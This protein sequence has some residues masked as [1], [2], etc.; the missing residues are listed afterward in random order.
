MGASPERAKLAR[1]YPTGTTDVS[2]LHYEMIQGLVETHDAASRDIGLSRLQQAV[3]RSRKGTSSA[4]REAL[5]MIVRG[6]EAAGQPNSALV[7]L[8][9]VVQLNRDS[10]VRNVLQHHHLHLAKVSRDLDR[11]AQAAIEMQ[12]KELRFQRLS[13]DT[14]RQC[15]QVLEKN[16]VAAELHDD[17][18][19]QACYRGGAVAK[20]AA[21]KKAKEHGMGVRR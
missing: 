3:H 8:H 16:T 14:L 20:E 21:P 11:Q 17:D 2:E 4:L 13:M 10:R 18:T 12:R 9:E 5:A 7:Y 15:M 19:R 6:Y 1:L